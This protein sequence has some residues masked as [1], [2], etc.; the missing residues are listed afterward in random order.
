MRKII[1]VALLFLSFASL[2]DEGMWLVNLLNQVKVNQMQQKGFALSA[3]DI[4]RT[5]SLSLKD[6]IVALDKGSCSGTVVSANGLLITNH[7]CAYSEIQQHSSPQFDYLKN[8]FFAENREQELP[9]PGKTVSFLVD[10][11][12]VTQQV[13]QQID[14]Q[15]AKGAES[16]NMMRIR[17]SIAREAVK[18]TQYDA[19]VHAMFGGNSYYLYTYITYRDVRLVGFPPECIGNFGGETDNW[20]WPRHT[21][22]FALFRIYT[23]P[24]GSSA[25]YSTE[26]VPLK[27]KNF[28]RISTKGVDEEDFVMIL[29]YPGTTSRYLSSYGVKEIVEVVD[30]IRVAF[31]NAKL[32]VL[33]SAMKNNDTIRIKYSSKFSLASNYWKYSV[34]ELK[35]VRENN[36]I[37]S[38][39]VY[40]KRFQKWAD[41]NSEYA[42][43]LAN[44]EDA[45]SQKRKV[46]T[47]LQCYN[48]G[49]L[50]GAEIFKLANKMSRLETVI[51]KSDGEKL[52]STVSEIRSGY[53][54]L[55]KDFDEKV[56]RDIFVVMAKMLV[57][58]ISPDQFPESFL[59]MAQDKKWNMER[60]ADEMYQKS[61]FVSLEKV[62]EFLNNPSLKVLKSDPA[63]ILSSAFYPT[64]ISLS[65]EEGQWERSIRQN[66]KLFI[67]AQMDMEPERAFYPDANSTMRLTYGNVA[68]YEPTDGIVYTYRTTTN[69][70]LQ[71]NATGLPE[72]VMPDSLLSMLASGDFG[73]FTLSDGA[74]PTCFIADL[75]ITGGNSG[76]SVLNGN[77]NLVGLA[78]DGNW[79]AMSGDILFE[80]TKQRCICV[81]IRY[82]LFL[83]SKLSGNSY[84]LND[85]VFAEKPNFNK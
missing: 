8:G 5:D 41:E 31:R 69:G 65:K 29:G 28:I 13:N 12:D 70:V 42:K 51:Q 82:V 9:N 30:P 83:I 50:F 18:G 1:A 52:A 62:N 76:S 26:N 77:G 27:S 24:D 53:S 16:P 58:R 71:K 81:D 7:H 75:D 44:L 59:R 47:L 63:F 15:L 35:S 25:D 48:E 10:V 84:V 38:K 32:D 66:H 43:V 72:Y 74:M 21:G 85:L 37:E 54:Y 61:M 80:P 20:V 64:I 23:A 3:K 56:D 14:E 34:G 45:Y 67:R 36:V 73:S 4:Y 6:A 46:T 39:Q 11:R 22:D 49:I 55:Y 68:G 19:E 33:R 2:A 79:E 60:F 57:S 17:N 40:E 78:F